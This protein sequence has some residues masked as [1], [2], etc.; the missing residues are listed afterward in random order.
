MK[1][2][3]PYNEQNKRE[4]EMMVGKAMCAYANYTENQSNRADLIFNHGIKA[5]ELTQAALESELEATERCIAMF[6]KES[7]YEIGVTVIERANEEFN[8]S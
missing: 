6:V 5:F 7:M 2:L 8:L 4:V 3:T 1:N